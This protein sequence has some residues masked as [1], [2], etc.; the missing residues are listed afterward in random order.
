MKA[1]QLLMCIYRRI[2]DVIH[3]LWRTMRLSTCA[4]AFEKVWLDDNTG[5]AA[6]SW[7]E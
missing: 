4:I 5:S 2:I 6:T 1:E 7:L 3:N